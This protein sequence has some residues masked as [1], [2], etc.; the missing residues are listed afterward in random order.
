MRKLL[1]FT[2][3]ILTGSTIG[4]AVAILLAPASGDDMRNEARERFRQLLD[5]SARAAAERRVE[6]EA[7]LA[8]LTTRPSPENGKNQDN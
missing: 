3:G 8:Q 7:E 1:I 4:A 6:L 2:A 5:E